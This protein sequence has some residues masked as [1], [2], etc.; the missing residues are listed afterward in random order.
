MHLCVVIAGNQVPVVPFLGE[1]AL[2]RVSVKDNLGRFLSKTLEYQFYLEWAKDF[3]G[4]C[5]GIT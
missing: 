4:R 1:S 5:N 3:C 2:F